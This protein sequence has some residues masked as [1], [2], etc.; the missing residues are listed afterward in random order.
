MSDCEN[1][2]DVKEQENE[3]GLKIFKPKGNYNCNLYNCENIIC[4]VYS[5]NF[6]MNKDNSMKYLHISTSV[7]KA[8]QFVF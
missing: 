3:T 4:G 6:I 7:K 2:Y 8:R 5:D 1:E